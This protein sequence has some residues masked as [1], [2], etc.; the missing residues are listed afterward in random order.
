MFTKNSL[1]A[2]LAGLALAASTPAAEIRG[3]ISKV[4]GENK[5][6]VIEGLGKGGRGITFTFVLTDDTRILFGANAGSL[7]DLVVG[8]RT[9]VVFDERD[10]KQIALTLR[11]LYPQPKSKDTI[12]AVPTPANGSGGVLRLINSNDREI[13]VVGADTK[14]GESETTLHFPKDLKVLRG[15]KATDFDGL[16]EGESLSFEA[17]KKDGKFMAKSVRVGP[18]DPNAKQAPAMLPDGKKGEKA[19]KVLEIVFQI[20]EQMKRERQ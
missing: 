17:E 18:P 2:L 20:L 6:L 5:A 11:P 10:G 13:V 16:K 3:I 8:R 4:D 14:G 7:A 12:S 9:R 15:E 19:M 1:L